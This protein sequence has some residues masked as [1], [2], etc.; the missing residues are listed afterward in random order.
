M[1]SN[2]EQ[3][4]EPPA[5]EPRSVPP[6]G[7]GRRRSRRK[8]V[9]FFVLCALLL[10][11]GFAWHVRRA[12][13]RR[14][15]LV[16][17]VSGPLLPGT[18]DV[19]YTWHLYSGTFVPRPRE[20]FQVSALPR[21]DLGAD[22]VRRRISRF[23]DGDGRGEHWIVA[24]GS[25]AE[26]RLFDFLR[27]DPFVE[28]A[29]TDPRPFRGGNYVSWHELE[30]VFPKNASGRVNGPSETETLAFRN[31]LT[32]FFEAE[33][34]RPDVAFR[35]ERQTFFLSCVWRGRLGLRE[36]G[37]GPARPA[38]G[39]GR[40]RA[41]RNGRSALP[42]FV[43]DDRNLGRRPGPRIPRREKRLR[44]SADLRRPRRHAARRRN[45]QSLRQTQAVDVRHSLFAGEP[46]AARPGIFGHA[47]RLERRRG[48]GRFFRR[49]HAA[50]SRVR[51]RPP[52]P[53]RR[54]AIRHAEPRR[55]GISR[56]ER[57]ERRAESQR[58]VRGGLTLSTNTNANP[59]SARFSRQL[60]LSLMALPI[61]G[62]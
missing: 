20:F 52:P 24:A 43:D 21:R 27:A 10:A 17:L 7:A 49:S 38:F 9:V 44:F 19:E 53:P 22:L 46:P 34:V 42:D 29:R 13:A 14:S 54:P 47:H 51:N 6:D 60:A 25:S 2:A 5:S 1:N 56:G 3:T 4:Q 11:G 62:H 15:E 16:R 48:M 28:K 36:T 55:V 26:N 61:D 50:L 12:E 59:S 37:R 31:R 18:A 32:G 41:G 40:K 8:A 45:P 35:E 39:M 30:A 23:E 58:G 57:R 33:S